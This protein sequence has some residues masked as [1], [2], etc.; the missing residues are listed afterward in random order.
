MTNPIKTNVGGLIVIFLKL[1]FKPMM[2]LA[3]VF[4]VNDISIQ[5]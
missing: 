5:K 1:L 4:K 3:F 2:E